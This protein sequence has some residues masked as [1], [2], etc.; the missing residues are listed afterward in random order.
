MKGF[1]SFVA[2]L[3]AVILLAGMLP[4]SGAATAEPEGEYMSMEE[5]AVYVRQKLKDFQTNFDF[6]F[7]ME[8]PNYYTDGNLMW[9][10]MDEV[11]EHTGVPDEGDYMRWS[12]QQYGFDLHDE[13]D[14]KTHY[15]SVNGFMPKYNNGALQE[16][17][18][19]KKVKEIL[20]SLELDGKT[21][22][23]KIKA[24]Y[25]YICENVEYSEEVL[26]SDIN[27]HTPPDDMKV[28]WSAYGAL[29]LGSATCQGFTMAVYRFL[30]PISKMLSVI[31]ISLKTITSQ[32]ATVICL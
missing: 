6:K 13:F 27:L 29:C 22:Y 12:F 2:A 11:F 21:D 1:R 23:E 20:E 17:L 24:I 30:V 5:V 3:L 32:Q 14:G 25:T 8:D 31:A 26:S 15:V 28:Y 10:F 9:I 18:L 7:R 16:E 4:V 19:D